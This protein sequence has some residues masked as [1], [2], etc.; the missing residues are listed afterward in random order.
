MMHIKLIL[1]K[2]EVFI[3]KYF[4]HKVFIVNM[5]AVVDYMDFKLTERRFKRQRRQFI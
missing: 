1:K 3:H 2:G 4:M 5:E